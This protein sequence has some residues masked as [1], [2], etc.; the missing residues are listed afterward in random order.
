MDLIRDRKRP[1]HPEY[2]QSSCPMLAALENRG[3]SVHGFSTMLMLS[4][5][6]SG[7]VEGK[8]PADEL[9]R[10]TTFVSTGR[11]S[12]C[13]VG[14]VEVHSSED[15]SKSPTENDDKN[16]DEKMGVDVSM[17]T[18]VVMKRVASAW[19]IEED[20]FVVEFYNTH[21]G[22]WRKMS[23]AIKL[24][25]G[26]S[27]SD[28][29]LRNRRYRLVSENDG[30]ISVASDSTTASRS[31]PPRSPW[32]T[33]EDAVIVQTLKAWHGRITWKAIARKLPGRTPHAIRNRAHRLASEVE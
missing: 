31:K 23:R 17:T 27:R 32:T 19:S 9:D 16:D 13:G 10:L 20:A 6:K 1:S 30:P 28:D 18:P 22:K 4:M 5:F 14:E 8:I 12:S 26:T 29:A 24:E 21:G 2:M 33:L 25:L 11:R 3:G 7:Y 15:E